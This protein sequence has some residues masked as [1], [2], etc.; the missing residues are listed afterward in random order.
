M[1]VAVLP[2]GHLLKRASGLRQ[3]LGPIFEVFF[4]VKSHFLTFFRSR[5]HFFRSRAIKIKF[6]VCTRAFK[7]RC[8][9]H[10]R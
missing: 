5:S 4:H 8:L 6:L 7:M 1:D 2:G 10:S 3:F 9:V